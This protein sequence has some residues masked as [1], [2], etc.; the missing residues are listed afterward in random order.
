MTFY[1]CV[2]IF[3]YGHMSFFKYSP[4]T[5]STTVVESSLNNIKSRMFSQG[6]LPIRV[7]NFILKHMKIVDGTLK[8]LPP[9]NIKSV[10][11]PQ[12]KE[13]VKEFDIA[14]PACKM[15]N[16][17]TGAHKCVVCKAAMHVLIE[18]S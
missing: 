5:A 7:D 11:S 18:C 8:L 2:K 17:L 10:P 12:F 9:K 14:C 3:Q 6:K 1:L 4:K 15:E 13:P 16:M